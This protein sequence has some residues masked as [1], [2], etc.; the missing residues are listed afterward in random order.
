[1][2]LYEYMK[3]EKLSA[4]LLKQ[5]IVGRLMEN[6]L[7]KEPLMFKDVS[8]LKEIPTVVEEIG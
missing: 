5:K 2:I 3:D 8:E 4:Y 7:R 1:M 6:I